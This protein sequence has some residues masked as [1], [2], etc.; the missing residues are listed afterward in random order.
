VYA[1]QIVQ[2]LTIPQAVAGHPAL[3]LCNTFAGWDGLGQR[4]YLQSYD[5]LVVLAEAQGLLEAA[6]STR[7]RSMGRGQPA[8]ATRVLR[9]TLRFRQNLYQCLTREGD[10][11]ALDAMTR[12]LRRSGSVRRLVEIAAD[13]S[14]WTF[15]DDELRLPL[16]QFVWWAQELLSKPDVA[17]VRPCPGRGCGWLF[18]DATGRRRW[19]IMALCGNRNKARR[20]VERQHAEA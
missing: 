20:F 1:H 15:D 10:R 7:L 14:R 9:A 4:E 17:S 18:Q 19:C 16:H 5:H 13:G 6:T 3:E 2:G 11:D 12:S 8:G